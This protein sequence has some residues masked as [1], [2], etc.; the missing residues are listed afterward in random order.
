M[1]TCIAFSLALVLAL[2][3]AA[4]GGPADRR[5]YTLQGQILSI[6]PDHKE[7]N[8]KHEE[9]KGFM[10][11]MTMPYKVRDQKEYADLTPGDLVN[12]T[13]VVVSNDAYL[14]DVKKVGNAPLEKPAASSAP[15]ASSGFELLKNGEPVPNAKF[16]NQD[17]HDVEFKSFKGKEVV[18]TFIST[19]CPM[20]TFCPLMDRHFATI[21]TKLKEKKN[22]LDVQLLSVIFDPANDTPP[23]LKRH[24]QTLAADPKIWSFVTG[25]RDDID[26][27]ASRFG[28]SVSRA[29]NDPANITHN[30]RTAIVDRQGNLV[31][32]YTGNEWT[33]E[34]V[35]ADIRVMI[36][37]D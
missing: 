1:R 17:G 3:A 26:Q 5:E 36:G 24:A 16:V 18:V 28:V 10:S 21:Q 30:L 12:A 37:V 19:K 13:L 27:W 32:T 31:Q 7:A 6:A 29:M 33:P 22:D 8:I 35:L 34:Q 14:K 23:V 11:A 4:C 25:D 15:S 2:L 9:I 20:P